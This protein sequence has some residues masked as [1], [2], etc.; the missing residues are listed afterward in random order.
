VR[1]R[2]LDLFPGAEVAIHVIR[3][4]ADKDES[5]SIR[6]G[7][8]VGVFV[9]EIEEALLRGEIDAAVHS[10]KD[11]PTRIPQG[12][13]IAAVPQREDALDALVTPDGKN[14]ANLPQGARVGTGSLRRQAQLL[15]LRP[16]LQVKDIRGNIDTRLKKLRAGAYDAV[17]LACAGLKRLGLADA[18]TQRLNLAEM[19]PAP[20][21]GALAVETRIGDLRINSVTAALNHWETAVAVAAERAFLS[22]MG[23]GCNVPVAAHARIRDGSLI[24]DGLVASPDGSKMVRDTVRASPDAAEDAAVALAETILERGGRAVLDGLPQ[25]LV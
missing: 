18:A 4:S 11:L 19:L 22:R 10:M 14:L 15:A 5:A 20:G 21:Q 1:E 16:D 24:L 25:S 13:R 7:S 3:T 17:V 8:A 2:I 12:L 9:R 23:G 6:S